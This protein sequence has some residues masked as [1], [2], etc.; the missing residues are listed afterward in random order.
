MVWLVAAAIFVAPFVLT[1]FSRLVSAR[2]ALVVFW[3]GCLC[4]GTWFLVEARK[5]E[6]DLEAIQIYALPHTPGTHR[7][8]IIP[9][10]QKSMKAVL[11]GGSVVPAIDLKKLDWRFRQPFV[12]ATWFEPKEHDGPEAGET[13]LFYVDYWGTADGPLTLEYQVEPGTAALLHQ[14]SL[15]VGHDGS[16][17]HMIRGHLLPVLTIFEWGLISWGALWMIVQVVLE[18]RRRRVPPGGASPGF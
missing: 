15:A 9:P 18:I 8:S 3:V 6:K 17:R 2:L 16:A 1:P 5:A 11:R 14:R 10:S 4:G 7:I 12:S 13:L